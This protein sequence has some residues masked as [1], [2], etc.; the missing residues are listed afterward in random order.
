MMPPVDAPWIRSRVIPPRRR[1]SVIERLG[2]LTPY[3]TQTIVDDALA[4]GRGSTVHLE[5]MLADSLQLLEPLR[6]RVDVLTGRGVRV[7]IQSGSRR[8]PF[9]RSSAA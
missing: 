2:P 9:R 4:S 7:V 6:R 1:E 5:L 3:L 8:G